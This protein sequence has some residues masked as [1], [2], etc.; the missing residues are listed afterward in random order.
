MRN[1][2]DAALLQRQTADIELRED[3]HQIQVASEK[4]DQRDL[5]VQGGG[6]V[7]GGNPE[8]TVSGQTLCEEF[9]SKPV[10]GAT[11]RQINEGSDSLE[12]I[13]HYLEADAL[14][15]DRDSHGLFDYEFK[16][17]KVGHLTTVGCSILARE[18]Y[19]LKTVIPRLGTPEHYQMLLT[20]VYK[21][22]CY[23]VF[24]KQSLTKADGE[25]DDKFNHFDQAWQII[26]LQNQKIGKL[27]TAE[28][29]QDRTIRLKEIQDS[30]KVTEGDMLKFGR[31]RFRIKKLVIEKQRNSEINRI[32]SE[33]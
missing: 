30:V 18:N 13:N 24:H 28:Q 16:H 26:R 10:Q 31:V 14:F 27:T 33:F 3:H 23:W 7:W 9:K 1:A 5:A 32:D 20:I 21:A 19:L 4:K 12:L 17:L 22:G 29:I 25:G 15:W 11:E 2:G 8:N 6:L